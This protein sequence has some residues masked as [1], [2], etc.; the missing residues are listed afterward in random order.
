MHIMNDI[1]WLSYKV[2]NKNVSSFRERD[3]R[4]PLS[5]IYEYHNIY[6]YIYEI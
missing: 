2:V 4:F 3:Q 1:I 5:S 6:I